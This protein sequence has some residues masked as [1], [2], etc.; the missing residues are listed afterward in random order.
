LQVRSGKPVAI[1]AFAGASKVA[2]P[3]TQPNVFPLYGLFIAIVRSFIIL[4]KTENA[5]IIYY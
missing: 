2:L 4:D 3:G 1:Y 5:L